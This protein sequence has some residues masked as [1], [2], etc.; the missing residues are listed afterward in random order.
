MKYTYYFDKYLLNWFD[1][2]AYEINPGDAVLVYSRKHIIH[3]GTKWGFRKDF[4][5]TGYPGNSDSSIRRFHGWR[6]T[7]N[8]ICT[9]AHGVYTVKTVETVYRKDEDGRKAPFL[10]VVLNKTDI[11]RNED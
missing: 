4:A 2:G 3:G 9:E 10:K 8:D 6:G 11:K 1:T 7:T 5:E